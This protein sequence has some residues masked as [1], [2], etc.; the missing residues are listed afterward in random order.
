MVMLSP[1]KASTSGLDP[2]ARSPPTSSDAQWEPRVVAQ[3]LVRAEAKV[4]FAQ[5]IFEIYKFWLQLVHSTTLSH[6]M[7]SMDAGVVAAFQAID[8]VIESNAYR[9]ARLAYARLPVVMSSLHAIISVDRKQG[10][11]HTAAGYRNASVALD[12]Y[13][14]AQ[15]SGVGVMRKKLAKRVRLANRWAHL[16]G[17]QPLLLVSFP[18]VADN[19]M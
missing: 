9:L 18:D 13:L 10:R 4:T 1:Q 2:L 16:G 8:N 3:Q 12:I 11:I 7:T 14:S 19:I 17:S 15:R 5:N 6:N